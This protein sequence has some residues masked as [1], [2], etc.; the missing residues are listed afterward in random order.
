M[1]SRTLG[2]N[3]PD[4]SVIGLGCMGMSW[5]YLEQTQDTAESTRAIQDAL[6][7][8]VTHLDTSDLYGPFT[9]EKLVGQ[10]LAGMTN[11]PVVATKGGLIANPGSRLGHVSVAP[12][13]HPDHLRSACEGSLRR[14]GLDRIDLYYLHRVDPAVPLAE[15]WGELATLVHEG[16]IAHLGLS[17]ITAAQLTEAHALHPVAAVQSEL[18]LWTRDPLAEI[19]PWCEAH[20]VGFVA[21]SPLGRGFLAGRFTATSPEPDDFRS[22]L[23]RFQ[24]EQLATNTMILDGVRR[25][26][27][28]H[29][30]PPARIALAWVLAQGSRVVA[31]PGS[32][33][34]AHM[35]DNIASADLALTSE[36]LADLDDLPLAAGARY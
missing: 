23:P 25:V 27:A 28:R 11:P 24:P 20:N 6:D 17:E 36:D 1:R 16:K 29:D 31:I 19:L 12:N 5:V 26:A 35:L 7:A 14:L 34:R 32:T 30:V 4:V 21:F 9:N 15:S 13:G 3:G 33:K 22:R 8:G 18:S 10:V 2:L